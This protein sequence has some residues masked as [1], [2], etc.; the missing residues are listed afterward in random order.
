MERA[1]LASA[2][3]R[4]MLLASPFA[5]YLQPAVFVF[6]EARFHF[7]CRWRN[8]GWMNICCFF[9]YDKNQEIT[10]CGVSTTSQSCGIGCGTFLP[11][12]RRKYDLDSRVRFVL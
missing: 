7:H 6:S 5:K 3:L 12:N 4:L 8:S 11:L 9:D 1:Q 10:A 2:Q